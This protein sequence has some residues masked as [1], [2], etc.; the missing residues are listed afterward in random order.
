M[1]FFHDSISR[2]NV[3]TERFRIYQIHSPKFRAMEVIYRPRAYSRLLGGG[4]DDETVIRYSMEQ[5]LHSLHVAIG[6]VFTILKL[7]VGDLCL[8]QHG[9]ESD[10]HSLGVRQADYE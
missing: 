7:H 8:Q 3:I 6:N 4:L 1:R 9:R 5:S 2:D 10:R